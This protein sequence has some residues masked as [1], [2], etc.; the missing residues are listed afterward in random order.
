MAARDIMPWRSV[1]GGT[2]RVKWAPMTASEVF[3]TGE[4]V[5]VVAAGT[6][7]EPVGATTSVVVGDFENGLGGI[8]VI[9]PGAGN[10]N[11]ATGDAFATGDDVAYWPFGDGN[12]FI[13][14]N[15]FATGDT[16]TAHVPV[17]ADVGTHYKMNQA[18]AA[19]AWGIEVTA[20]LPGV[21]LVC[22]ITEVLDVNKAPLRVSGGTGVYMVFE[23]DKPTLAENN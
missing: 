11:P 18:A 2:Y 23:V 10:I 8:A 1:L 13:T 17:Q 14:D 21:D 22:L 5:G 20:A 19:T 6:L 7:T 15:A 12:E 4:P 3:E 9:G 16:T